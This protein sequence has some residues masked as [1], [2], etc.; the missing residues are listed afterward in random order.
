MGCFYARSN[1]AV[2]DNR[3]HIGGGDRKRAKVKE[4]GEQEKP[5]W[6]YEVY[7]P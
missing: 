3:K 1:T 7:N 6:H 5:E 4:S 2:K